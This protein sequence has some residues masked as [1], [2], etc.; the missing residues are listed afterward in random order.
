MGMIYSFCWL[1]ALWREFLNLRA[2]WN[3]TRLDCEQRVSR[4]WPSQ[5]DK[6]RGVSGWVQL[7]IMWT[8]FNAF[9]VHLKT[10]V[11]IAPRLRSSY[12]ASY[13]PRSTC[14][15]CMCL[16]QDLK[17]WLLAPICGDADCLKA[18]N[19]LKNLQLKSVT[20]SR[21]GMQGKDLF[22]FNLNGLV[23]RRSSHL[24]WHTSDFIITHILYEENNF[25][26]HLIWQMS[27]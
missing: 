3:M 1:V 11:F 5:W 15:L 13:L 16:D 9:S 17:S 6:R 24:H 19:L 18:R 2:I 10:G 12:Q 27:V 7:F 26:F 22:L 25:I 8:R 4:R 23:V 20:S 14:A 21:S